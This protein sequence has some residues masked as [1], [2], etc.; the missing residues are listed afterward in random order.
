V[1]TQSSVAVVTSSTAVATTAMSPNGTVVRQVVGWSVVQPQVVLTG[2]GS[3]T[4]S[5]VSFTG[6]PPEA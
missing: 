3:A 4:V 6:T 1:S 5:V 2:N